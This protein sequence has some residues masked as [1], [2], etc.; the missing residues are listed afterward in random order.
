MGDPSHSPRLLTRRVACVW[1]VALAA[2]LPGAVAHAELPAVI[3]AN[4]CAGAPATASLA[5]TTNRTGLIDIYYFRPLGLPVAFYEC[6]GGRA[7]ALGNLPSAAGSDRTVLFGAAAWSCERPTRH[8]AATTPAPGGLIALGTASVRTRSCASRFALEAPDRLARGKLASVR[9]VDRWD[10]GNMRARLCLTSPARERHCRRVAFAKAVGAVTRRFRLP[11]RG[12]WRVDLHVGGYRVRDVIAVGLRGRPVSRK[13]LPTVLAT[14]D[15]TMMGVESF[16]SDELRDEAT[17]VSDTRPG[18]ALSGHNEWSPVARSQV[19]TLWPDVT[20]LSIGANEGFPMGAPDGTVLV[21]C[22]EAW[23]AEYARRMRATLLTYAHRGHG[24]VFALTIAAPRDGARA[25]ITAAVNTGIVRA[26]EGL[27]GVR[28]LRMD[29]VFSPDG[30]REV[31]RYGGADV[32]V[33]E[34]DGTHLNVSGTAI[35]ARIVAAA[36]RAPRG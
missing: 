9:V 36:I 32:D 21:C 13:A 4:P 19:A 3:A 24:R 25:A 17:V 34:P 35:E 15:S 1:I 33:R 12:R 11:T 26:A 6:V 29:L 5:L 8:F 27:A 20:V 30:F 14:G 18:L 28:V 23:V 31:I 2:L 7:L 16:L 10:L 22:D